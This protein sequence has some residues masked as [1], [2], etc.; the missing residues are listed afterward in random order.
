[1]AKRVLLLLA[2]AVL[3][4]G[5]CLYAYIPPVPEL[6]RLNKVC[7]EEGYYMAE[8]EYRMLGL[9]YY[10]DRGHYVKAITGLKRLHRRLATRDGLV[11]VPTSGDRNEEMA[12]YLG[13]QNPRTGAFMDD[14]YPLCV[15][16][17]PTENVLLHLGALADET[18]QPLRLRHP[19]RYLDEI[20]TPDR[21]R[22]FLDDVS[23]VG[24]VG[25]RFPQTSFHLAR[26]LLSSYSGEG[27]AVGTIEKHGLYT[28]SPEWKQTLLQWFYENQDPG[29]GF[30]GPRLRGSGRLAK[31]DLNNTASIVKSFVDRNGKDIR[32]SFPLRYRDRVFASTLHAMSQPVPPVDDTDE[33]HEWRLKMGKGSYLLTRYLWKGATGENRT[34]A[35]DLFE[36]YV[37]TLFERCFVRSEGAFSYYPDADHATVDGTGGGIGL[38]ANLGALSAEK[39]RRLWGGPAETCTDLGSFRVSVLTDTVFAPLRGLDNTNSWRFYSRLPSQES[40]TGGVFGVHYP[41]ATSVLDIAELVPGVRRW[42]HTTTQSMGN[43]VSREQI[44]SR[45]AD[46]RTEPVPVSRGEIPLKQMTDLLQEHGTLTVIGYDVLQVPRHRITFFL[47]RS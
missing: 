31:L 4:A 30:W 38:F 1:V 39:Q 22:A 24:W 33:W 43:W 6:F 15:Y 10:L 47:E 23:T 42:T 44:L 37:R 25:S 45:L 34:K 40:S 8:F 21:L 32:P 3:A 9:A 35:R 7:Q 5:A 18:G 41:G 14:F 13:L 17:G 36:G 16:H 46:V 27:Q 12:F 20:G 28:F 2:F 11:R 26:D 19:L 29:T